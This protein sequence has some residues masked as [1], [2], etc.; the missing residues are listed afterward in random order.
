MPTFRDKIE[1]AVRDAGSQAKLAERLGV[2][3]QQISYLLN[4]AGRVSAEMAVKLETV[5]GIPREELRP[6]IFGKPGVAA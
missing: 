2:S 5:L 4:D 6:D 3:Q 1:A